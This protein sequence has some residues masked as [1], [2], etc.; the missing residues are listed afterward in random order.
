MAIVWID[1]WDAQSRANAK[2]LIN[3]S[4]NIGKDKKIQEIALKNKKL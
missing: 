4:F 3:R 2:R 1:I